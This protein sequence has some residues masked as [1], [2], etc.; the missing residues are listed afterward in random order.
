MKFE[1]SRAPLTNEELSAAEAEIGVRFPPGLRDH[2]LRTNGGVPDPYI[3]RR[4]NIEVAISQCLP[5]RADGRRISAMDVYRH[6]VLKQGVIPKYLFPF[7]IDGGG[8]PFLV[9]CRTDEGW[10]YVWWHDVSDNNLDDLRTGIGAFWNY[11]GDG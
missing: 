2:Y 9:D 8:N 6:L 10:V 11:V 1:N 3:F 4:G 7:A 5:L